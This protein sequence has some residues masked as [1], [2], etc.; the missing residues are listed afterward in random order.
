M[1]DPWLSRFFMPVKP[2]KIG[3]M[4]TLPADNGMAGNEI[5]AEEEGVRGGHGPLFCQCKQEA[6]IRPGHL[7]CVS[8]IRRIYSFLH[9]LRL[10][11][12]KG[13]AYGKNSF[14]Y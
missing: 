7:S 10:S 1:Q 13:P 4:A 3:N 14:V 2:V 11:Q 5:G 9:V 8:P 6:V 12:L